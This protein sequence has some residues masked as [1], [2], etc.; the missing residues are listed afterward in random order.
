MSI[1]KILF[2]SLNTL[3]EIKDHTTSLPTEDGED[4]SFELKGSDQNSSFTPHSKKKLGKEI[5]AFANTYGGILCFHC[6]IDDTNPE[7]FNPSAASSIH[8]QVESWLNECIKPTIF[9]LVA[10][11]VDGL[12]LIHIPESKN[13]PHQ[14]K[15][16]YY[17]RQT[18]NALAM[19]EVMISA[20]YRSRDYL[21]FDYDF[22]FKFVNP[23]RIEV[24]AHIV[25][26]SSVAGTNPQIQMRFIN[27]SFSP[28]LCEDYQKLLTE[29]ID[30]SDDMCLS[31]ES[32]CDYLFTSDKLS[33]RILY[34]NGTL[35]YRAVSIDDFYTQFPKKFK[36]IVRSQCVFIE[37]AA[38]KK[39]HLFDVDNHKVK[40]V[41]TD[42]SKIVN[43]M[44]RNNGPS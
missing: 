29:Q 18:R 25:N 41:G 16:I 6:G 40:L 14:Y 36:M 11:P 26:R 38:V 35:R 13:K 9:G 20:L 7:P 42:E 34:P 12:I 24:T 30:K 10:K 44:D 37:R 17:H 39:I 8:G 27:L 32:H 15:D 43:L 3:Q 1:H 31:H 21:E 19:P 28:R 22:E 5:C 33:Q 23:L 4:A 2:D